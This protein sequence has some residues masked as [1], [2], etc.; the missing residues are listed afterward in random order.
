[1]SV[2]VPPISTAT[3][4]DDGIGASEIEF[5]GDGRLAEND[6]ASAADNGQ[7]H[8]SHILRA[9]PSNLTQPSHVFAAAERGNDHGKVD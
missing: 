3:L 8:L 4:I 2:N 7:H 9:S 6:V 1:M 5:E